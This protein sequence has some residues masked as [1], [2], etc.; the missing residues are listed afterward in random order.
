MVPMYLQDKG[1]V[2]MPAVAGM[3]GSQLSTLRLVFKSLLSTE[4]WLYD[5]DG[6]P[7]PYRSEVEYGANQKVSFALFDSDGIVAPH[8][9]IA[10]ALRMVGDALKTESHKVII[11]T[12]K[13]HNFM[14]IF[15]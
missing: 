4:P 13:F 5:P 7:I 8:P 14:L 15:L 6:V 2:A 11:I 1:Q 12:H 9:P 3:L 10:R